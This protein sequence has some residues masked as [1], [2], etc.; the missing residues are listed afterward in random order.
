[1]LEFAEKSRKQME[2]LQLE[3]LLERVCTQD[4]FWLE[5]LLMRQ[6]VC[7]QERVMQEGEQMKRTLAREEVRCELL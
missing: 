5:A 2:E 1:M 7:L 6:H 3:R 4:E